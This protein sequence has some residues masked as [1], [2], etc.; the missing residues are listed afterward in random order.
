MLR[1]NGGH[2]IVGPSRYRKL[3]SRG[4][5]LLEMSQIAFVVDF[6]SVSRPRRRY[7]VIE[8][9]KKHERGSRSKGR[10]FFLG[11]VAAVPLLAR[12]FLRDR[13]E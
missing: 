9:P 11:G 1:R 6:K 7:I 2:C 3:S 12:Y 4:S 5:K 8:E 10:A 13:I